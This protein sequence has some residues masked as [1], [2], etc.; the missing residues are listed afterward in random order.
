MYI[1]MN[2]FKVTPGSETAF[3][4]I[5]ANR[6]THLKEVPGFYEFHLLRGPR[7][8][9]Y[10]LYA[11]HSLWSSHDAFIDWTKSE[12]FRLAHRNAGS[13]AHGA[14]LVYVGPPEFEG[15]E[16]IQAEKK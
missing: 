3:E 6:E 8:D 2:R 7:H 14:A 16:I 9:A 13:G 1:A 4:H 15:F 12:A 10:T 11:S 5:W